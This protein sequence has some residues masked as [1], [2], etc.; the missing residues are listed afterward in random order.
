MM[1]GVCSGCFNES[2]IVRAQPALPSNE[3]TS[4]LLR[5]HPL[6]IFNPLPATKMTVLI[7]MILPL[8]QWKT[9]TSVSVDPCPTL[10]CQ[11]WC[12]FVLPRSPIN[13]LGLSVTAM[14]QKRCTFHGRV[15]YPCCF[16]SVCHEKPY[17]LPM[18]IRSKNRKQCRSA[19]FNTAGLSDLKQSLSKAVKAF[20][21]AETL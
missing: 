13:R 8:K 19:A 12:L 6:S 9:T 1:P 21:K 14:K 3:T 10:Y 15:I 2:S 5:L 17:F 18:K 4:Q 7:S 11:L 20:C 16:C